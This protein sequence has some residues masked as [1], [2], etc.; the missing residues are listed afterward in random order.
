MKRQRE[1]VHPTGHEAFTLLAYAEWLDEQGSDTTS[2][3]MSL[4]GWGFE[5]RA[6]LNR[7]LGRAERKHI[8]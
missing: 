2:L 7:M 5:D 3:R 1:P 8:H 4:D 6:H